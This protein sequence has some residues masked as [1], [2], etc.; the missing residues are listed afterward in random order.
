MY[1]LVFSIQMFWEY[2][3]QHYNLEMVIV[4]KQESTEVGKTVVSSIYPNACVQT[5]KTYPFIYTEMLNFLK[6]ATQMG[7][8][9]L[10]I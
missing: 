9:H 7:S 6:P 10:F 1:E 4:A 3:T 2:N 8:I 5:L